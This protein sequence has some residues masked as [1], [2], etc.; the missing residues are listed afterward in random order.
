MDILVQLYT[1][2]RVNNCEFE[3]LVIERIIGFVQRVVIYLGWIYPYVFNNW[4]SSVQFI[5]LCCQHLL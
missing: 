5:T 3:W 2:E 1:L 4:I